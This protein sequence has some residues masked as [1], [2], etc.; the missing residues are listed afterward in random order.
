MDEQRAKGL[1]AA[2]MG[3]VEALHRHRM[4]YQL[5]LLP[6]SQGKSTSDIVSTALQFPKV[7]LQFRDHQGH[8][9]EAQI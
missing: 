7:Q 1:T 8:D 3:G 2:L 6:R 5:S 4:L 9:P